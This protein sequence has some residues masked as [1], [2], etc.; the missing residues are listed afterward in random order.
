M[1][2]EERARRAIGW[3]VRDHIE[4]YRL[5]GIELTEEQALLKI[6]DIV[7]VA[8]KRRDFGEIK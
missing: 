3:M 2:R 7:R 5:Q 1:T 8:E 6:L 4:F